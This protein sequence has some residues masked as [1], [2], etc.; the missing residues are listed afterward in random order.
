[1][2]VIIFGGSGFLGSHVADVLTNAGHNVTIYDLKKSPYLMDTQEMIVGDILDVDRV[3]EAVK[4]ADI[5]YNFAGIADID[6]ASKKPLESIKYN[7]VGNSII[8]EACRKENIKRFV[9]ASSLY[10]Y[11]KAGSF[12]RST[13]QACELL[14]ENYHEVFGLNYTILRYGSLYGPR[15]DERNFIHKILKQALIEG[16]I[17]REGDGEELRDYIHVMDAARGSV[18]I[19]ADEFANQHVILVGNQQMRIK[20]LLIMIKEMLDNKIEI[21]FIPT[22]DSLHY[23]ITPYSFA[24]RV[25]KRLTSRT[26]LDL[27]QG[28]LDC[29]YDIYKQINPKP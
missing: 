20:D 8:L 2:K 25:G 18:E 26:Y 24:P 1:M 23:E 14:I 28:I 13:K 10:V 12:Y 27:G 15:A 19:L 17:T 22:T 4:N 3:E 9:F 11:S 7:I 29:I 6:E 16:K 5:V 21:E